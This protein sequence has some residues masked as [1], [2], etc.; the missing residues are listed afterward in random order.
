MTY[1]DMVPNGSA[2]ANLDVRFNNGRRVDMRSHE[3]GASALV[4]DSER[5]VNGT[6]EL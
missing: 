1:M 6:S 4:L 5:S 2:G 3:I